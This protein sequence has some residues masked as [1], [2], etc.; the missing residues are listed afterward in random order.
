M[1]SKKRVRRNNSAFSEQEAARPKAHHIPPQDRQMVPAITI[2]KAD[3]TPQLLRPREVLKLQ[4]QLGNQAVNRLLASKNQGQTTDL[5]TQGPVQTNLVEK[6]GAALPNPSSQ[7]IQRQP[8]DEI[9]ELKQ[10]F[11]EA[12]ILDNE[13]AMQIALVK[14]IYGEKIENP[15]NCIDREIKGIVGIV[16]N[17][18]GYEPFTSEDQK[19]YQGTLGEIYKKMFKESR[20]KE[21]SLLSQKQVGSVTAFLSPRVKQDGQQNVDEA[22]K[23]ADKLCTQE[24]ILNDVLEFAKKNISNIKKHF[25]QVFIKERQLKVNNNPIL[26]DNIQVNQHVENFLKSAISKIIKVINGKNFEIFFDQPGPGAGS[27]ATPNNKEEPSHVMNEKPPNF[28][29]EV[30]QK[31]ILSINLTETTTE[32]KEDDEVLKGRLIEPLE[33][34]TVIFHE[35]MH[36]VGG[37]L[38]GNKGGGHL[39]ELENYTDK[40]EEVEI[41]NVKESIKISPLFVDAYFMESIWHLYMQEKKN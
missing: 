21:G 8:P 9:S 3:L 40:K 4:R 35:L 13:K 10:Q 11:G 41:E 1:P 18:N 28:T 36:I 38:G 2:Q 19:G 33:I 25:I 37:N 14:L 15:E 31:Y 39:A 17:N 7:V 16:F 23:L 12:Q 24:N 6:Q 34:A 29:D 30:N 27:G 5:L 20:K 32:G 22:L 26:F